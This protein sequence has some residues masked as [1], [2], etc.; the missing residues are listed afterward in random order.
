MKR[1]IISKMTDTLL[2]GT[3]IQINMKILFLPHKEHN[4]LHQTSQCCL[5]ID[6]RK[7][8]TRNKMC[9]QKVQCHNVTPGE[10]QSH[11]LGFESLTFLLTK[12]KVWDDFFLYGGKKRRRRKKL[13]RYSCRNKK[14]RTQNKP[15]K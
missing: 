13:N 11:E 2:H 12:A 3:E 14:K 8:S 15:S 9:G 5:L 7:H 4:R 10:T 6:R 1:Q